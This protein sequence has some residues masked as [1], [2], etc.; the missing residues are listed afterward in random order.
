MIIVIVAGGMIAAG[1]I[2]MTN[3]NNRELEKERREMEDERTQ[4]A[5]ERRQF[6]EERDGF[7][8]ERKKW[9]DEINRLQVQLG[10]K[11][12]VGGIAQLLSMLL[13]SFL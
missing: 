4:L 10:D 7:G 5:E 2:A 11:E 3:K 9:L 8:D 13:E 6:G 12:M 1:A